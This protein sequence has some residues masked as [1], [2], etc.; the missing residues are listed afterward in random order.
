MFK[1]R[2]VRILC[3]G[4]RPSLEGKQFRRMFEV[5]SR[6]CESVEPTRT[7]A[8][9][10]RLTVSKTCSMELFVLQKGDRFETACSYD[11]SYSSVDPNNV[12]F[13]FG[14]EQEM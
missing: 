4:A 9:K 1:C 8:R 2:S 13:G 6:F 5:Q 10:G 3:E 7:V 14:S 11:T 12:T